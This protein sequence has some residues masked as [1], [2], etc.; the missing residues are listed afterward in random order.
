MSNAKQRRRDNF[1]R[2]LIKDSLHQQW[3][4]M[5]TLL[6]Y[7]PDGANIDEEGEAKEAANAIYAITEEWVLDPGLREE[8]SPLIVEEN[9]RDDGPPWDDPLD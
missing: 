5:G 1:Y 2:R 3:E 9:R 7:I 8:L 6:N 4:R